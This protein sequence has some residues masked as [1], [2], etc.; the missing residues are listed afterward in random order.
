M[1]SY[2]DD[3]RLLGSFNPYI[4]Q[5]PIDT[6]TQVGLWK[7]AKYDEGIQ[8]IQTSID[9]V[10]G[11]DIMRDVD[12]QY[13]QSKL[14][15][16]GGNLKMVAAG[17]FSNYQLV[18]SVSGMASKVGKDN[19]VIN[20]VSSTAF[21]R[22]QVE[23]MQ[24]DAQ[25]GKSNPAN[26]L[27]FNKRANAWFN[28]TTVG[29]RFNTPYIKPIDVWGKVKDIAGQIG[30]A[31]SD[32]ME[33]FETDAQGKYIMEKDPKDGTEHPRFNPIMAQKV[34]KGKD[35]AAVLSAF[36]NALTSADFQQLAMEGEY[37]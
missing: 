30:V 13:L 11:L 29:E 17:D 25:E 9:R 7:Q 5:L 32:I 1:S 37:N 28:S 34:L 23:Q 15:E 27:R 16:L 20:A 4:Q 8:K 19:N 33:L 24:K 6:M 36:Q 2:T 35:P 3:P 12:K 31:G 22:K 18:N 26:D 21:Y 10:A 14:T